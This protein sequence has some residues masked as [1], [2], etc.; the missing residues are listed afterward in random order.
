MKSALKAGRVA[1][2]G[3][4]AT[5]VGHSDKWERQEGNTAS[6]GG[7]GSR[8]AAS[9]LALRVDDHVI[10]IVVGRLPAIAA[11]IEAAVIARAEVTGAT[12]FDAAVDAYFPRA[13]RSRAD[14]GRDG[15]RLIRVERC[16]PDR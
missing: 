1:A 7:D 15:I 12:D 11:E 14:L 3:A 10:V 2:Q 16:R 8:G 4:R 13:I 9:A 5:A 6:T